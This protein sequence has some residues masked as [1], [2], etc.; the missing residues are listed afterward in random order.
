MIPARGRS[1]LE[2]GSIY[3]RRAALLATG[4]TFGSWCL[5]A[6]VHVDDMY[7]VYHVIGTWL[8]LAK[9]ANDGT[10]YPAL[11][12]GDA[13]GGTRYMPLQFLL[14]AGLARV[15][16]EYLV[17]SK[18]L[19]YGCSLILFAVLFSVCRRVNGS[20]ALGAALV[21]AVVSSHTGL[22]D[23]TVVRADTLPVALQLAAVEAATR[24]PAYRLRP[25]V[26]AAVLCTLAFFTKSTA[27][28]APLAVAIW[29]AI[30]DRRALAVFAATVGVSAAVL[31]GVLEAA[32]DGRMYENVVGLAGAGRRLSPLETLT[33]FEALS[34]KSANVIWVFGAVAIVA[35]V[36]GIVRRSLTIYHLSLAFATILVIFVL[37]DIGADANHLID[38]EVL[39]AVVFAEAVA[40][41]RHD[42]RMFAWGIVLV[43]ILWG[44][45]VDVRPATATA[46]RAITGRD[47]QFDSQ[48]PLRHTIRADDSVLAENPYVAV[49]RD[50][51]PT[52]LDPFMLVRILRDHPKWQALLIRQIEHHRY[53][54]VVLEH[55]LAPGSRWWWRDYSF[56]APVATAVRRSYR[57]STLPTN[58]GRVVRPARPNVSTST[59]RGRNVMPP[60]SAF[61]EHRCCRLGHSRAA[62]RLRAR[63]GISQSCRCDP[64]RRIALPSARQAS[65]AS[66]GDLQP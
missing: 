2:R 24:A 49:S 11:F 47:T 62:K 38:V 63:P 60:P 23:S 19:A 51:E 56:G 53:D 41:L 59:S 65:V 57:L 36:M 42:L 18:L 13:F 16:G 48:V 3:L 20:R 15:T 14:H 29:L 64:E 46:L 32:S 52:V 44:Y 28:W 12:D 25:H 33:K 45:A 17:S 5:I 61:G 27:I 10:L 39:I 7:R 37:R 6:S 1:T 40:T 26:V 21:A 31:F 9:Y 54:K 4:I 50:K 35:I 34:H 43:S 66:L 30:R 58:F 22:A 55:E 8:G